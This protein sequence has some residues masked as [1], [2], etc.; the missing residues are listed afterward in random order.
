M[1]QNQPESKFKKTPFLSIFRG[2]IEV[3]Q[4]EKNRVLLTHN[5]VVVGSNPTGPTEN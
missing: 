3:N 2:F 1:K 4:N 5:Q